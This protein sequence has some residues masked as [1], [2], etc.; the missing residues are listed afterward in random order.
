MDAMMAPCL[1]CRRHVRVHDSSCPFCGVA[2]A[3]APMPEREIPRMSRAAIV[4][5]A[6][7]GVSCAGADQS[8]QP[9]APPTTVAAA[10]PAAST[11]PTPSTATTSTPSTAPTPAPSPAPPPTSPPLVLGP[12][13]YPGQ[14]AYGAPPP[15][16]TGP[17]VAPAY[18]A[19]P[20]LGPSLPGPAETPT[21]Q[22]SITTNITNTTEKNS[23]VQRVTPRLRQCSNALAKVN[24]AAA[25]LVT[26]DA[27]WTET[28][29]LTV[30]AVK[31]N[32]GATF[33]TCAK[34]A[35][36]NSKLAARD[37]PL[38]VN[39]KVSVTPQK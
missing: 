39:A 18:G 8:A 35:L 12:T 36:V 32:V 29:A 28:G 24:P 34:A 23:F 38:S 26:I 33:E 31:G 37:A 25:G 7:L 5:M 27:T 15:P 30:S 22:L 6:S 21:L 11:A 2:L 9:V 14:S 19:P 4:A 16:F 10:P 3:L 17:T 13:P 1:A 20:P